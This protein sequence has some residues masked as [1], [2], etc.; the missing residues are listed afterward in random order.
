MSLTRREILQRFATIPAVAAGVRSLRKDDLL[1]LTI[2]RQPRTKAVWDKLVAMLK[3]QCDELG[4]DRYLI[5][6]KGVEATVMEPER[7]RPL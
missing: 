4:I 3:T 7:E 6:P 2:D 5:I 1:V